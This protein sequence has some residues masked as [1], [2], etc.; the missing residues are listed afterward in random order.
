MN[1]FKRSRGKP[2]IKKWRTIWC[3][4]D[5]PILVG[6]SYNIRS[7][8]TGNWEWYPRYVDEAKTHWESYPDIEQM[9]FRDPI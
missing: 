6:M 8:I 4:Y 5:G 2:H 7:A 1:F 9:F 3:V